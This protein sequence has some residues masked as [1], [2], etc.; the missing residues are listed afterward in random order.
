MKNYFKYRHKIAHLTSSDQNELIK[1]YYRGDN[2]KELIN[3]YKIDIKEN[4]FYLVL[5]MKKDLNRVCNYCGIELLF[6]PPSK[7]KKNSS[8]YIC[9]TCN[10][11][12]GKHDCMC[13]NCILKKQSNAHKLKL[14]RAINKTSKNSHGKIEL[15]ASKAVQLKEI[16]LTQKIYLG[17]LL[18]TYIPSKDC[19]IKVNKFIKSSLAPSLPLKYKI[20]DELLKNNIIFE[21]GSSHTSV[22]YAINILDICYRRDQ[23]QSITS[24][25]KVQNISEEL[26]QLIRDIQ[27]YEAIEYFSVVANE[28]FS[29]MNINQSSIDEMFYPLFIIILE[30]DYSIAQLYY[31]I[32][33]GIRYY[34]NK[35][36]CSGLTIN[37]LSE[38]HQNI[39]KLYNK[40]KTENWDITNYNRPYS[41]E[42]SELFNIVAND[43]LGVNESLFYKPFKL[44]L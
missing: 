29:I 25:T 23:F 32:Y 39:L 28:Q 5:P 4:L 34:V 31:F 30:N 18:R 40:A 12:E 14:K 17:A 1:R 8:V 10:H 26:L 27:S 43:L 36:Q 21:L 24:P 15:D 3:S 7:A 41:T 44:H 13:R 33:T 20:L 35:H 2:V 42:P 6:L 38:I 11:I 37:P 22:T 9:P 19:L 16:T